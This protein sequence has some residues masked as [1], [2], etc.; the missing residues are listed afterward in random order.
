MKKKHLSWAIVAGAAG[1]ALAAIKFL[2][3]PRVEKDE[4]E[5]N[6]RND[7]AEAFDEAR[8][9]KERGIITVAEYR[10]ELETIR[11]TAWERGK[12]AVNKLLEEAYGKAY[13]V[14]Y[15]HAQLMRDVEE[16]QSYSLEEYI[17]HHPDEADER[18][19]DELGLNQYAYRD[20][21]RTSSKELAEAYY[22]NLSRTESKIAEYVELLGGDTN[23]VKQIFDKTRA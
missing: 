17:R 2:S 12:A 19:R 8:N 20:Q 18:H 5:M 6:E 10:K 7:I 16:S 3:N 9:K 14:V 23:R 13:S 21:A 1:A 15:W 11:N 4:F 22:E